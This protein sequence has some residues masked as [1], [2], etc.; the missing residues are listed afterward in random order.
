MRGLLRMLPGQVV[1][2]AFEVQSSQGAM[3]ASMLGIE[4]R[5]T[6]GGRFG[7]PVLGPMVPIARATRFPPGPVGP[8][9]ATRAK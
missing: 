7:R 9:A 1:L 4:A 8:S 6:P 2:L 5:G 3:G